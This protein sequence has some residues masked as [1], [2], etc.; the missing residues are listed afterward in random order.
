MKDMLDLGYPLIVVLIAG[1]LGV[2]GFFATH[3]SERMVRK[4]VDAR[5]A[6][7]GAGPSPDR[8]LR[9]AL[10]AGRATPRG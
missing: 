5:G 8:P 7:S 1:G 4:S 3:V 6:L 2:L 9:Q 10:E